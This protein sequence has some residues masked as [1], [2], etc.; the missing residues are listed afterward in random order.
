M[1]KK[2]KTAGYSSKGDDAGRREKERRRVLIWPQLEKNFVITNPRLLDNPICIVEKNLGWKLLVHR[3]CA[4]REILDMLDHPFLPALYTSIQIHYCP[5]API[6][7]NGITCTFKGR[8]RVGVVGRT[9]SGKTKL[10]SALFCLVEPHRTRRDHTDG[11][12]IK[13]FCSV[14]NIMICLSKDFCT[15]FSSSLLIVSRCGFKVRPGHLKIIIGS[16][17][18]FPMRRDVTFN[19]NF[20]YHSRVR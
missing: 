18:G 9:R 1:M 14:C 12:S 3:A 11:V 2:K 10:I 20:Q 19:V 7:V 15:L 4:E 16:R 8:I 17:C 6:V 5:N 13:R